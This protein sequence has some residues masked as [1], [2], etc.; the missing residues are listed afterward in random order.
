MISMAS[1]IGVFTLNVL[2]CG[3]RLQVGRKLRRVSLL[4]EPTNANDVAG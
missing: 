1:G 3:P 2:G 4:K